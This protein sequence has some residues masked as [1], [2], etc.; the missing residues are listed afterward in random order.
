M[1][2]D[3]DI[4]GG[5][6]DKEGL[7]F[8]PTIIPFYRPLVLGVLPRWNSVAASGVEAPALP[9]PVIRWGGTRPYWIA[10]NKLLPV[11]LSVVLFCRFVLSKNSVSSVNSFILRAGTSTHTKYINSAHALS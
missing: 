1:P 11:P 10:Y 4:L 5:A 9:C 2:M 3:T 7:K 8:S 6:S